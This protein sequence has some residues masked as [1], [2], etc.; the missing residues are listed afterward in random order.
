MSVAQYDASKV[1]KKAIEAYT[2]GLENAQEDRYNEAIQDL[3]EAIQRD[4]KYV[5]AYLSLAGVY[6]Q[7]KNREQSVA[8]YEKAFT[9]DS[10]YTSDFR[11]PYSINLAGMGQFDKALQTIDALLAK[12]NLNPNTR[13]AAEYRRKTYQFALDY[14]K[15][16]PAGNYVFAPQNLGDEINTKES[17][18]FPSIPIESDKLVFTRRLRGMN[19]DFFGSMRQNGKWITA[20]PLPGNINT[21]MNE[22]A[23]NIS[24]DGTMLIFTGCNR[25]GGVGGCD[26]YISYLT[27]N[28]WSEAINLGNKVNSEG[29]DSQP[30]L[31]P[32][33]RDLYFASKRP[34]GLGGSDIYVTHL[35]SNGRWSEPENMGP[36]INTSGDEF[37]PFIHADNQTLYFTSNGLPGYGDEDLFVTR[38]GADGKWGTPQNLGYPINTINEEGTIFVAADSKTAYYSS[39]RSDSRGGL[40]IY[41]F[42]LRDDIRPFK[43]L[44]IKGKVFDKNTNAG[45]P[46]AVELIDLET[47]QTLSKVQTDE[48]GNYLITLPTGKD[49]AFNVNR[50]GYLFYSDNYSLKNKTAD[51]TYE[52]NIP[53]QP[54][55]A[56]AS[57]VLRNIFFDFNKYELKPESQIELDKVVQLLQDNPTVKI[58][59]EGHTD[60]IG[61]AADNLKL[62]ENRA[63]AAIAYISSKGI[64]P[65]R[66]ASKGFGATKPIADNKIEEGR[67]QNRRTELKVVSR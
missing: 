4:P 23:Q 58:Q 57:V 40:D 8:T 50:R 36:G 13:K 24:Q 39:D 66:L 11:L 38:R 63:K 61:N 35:Q 30:S 32:D 12:S 29:W 19:E 18:Y 14:A 45:L 67:A 55:E 16:H 44:W 10:N 47:K 49:Y 62:S 5:E 42:E 60:N 3:Q 54:I 7:M 20:Q 2:R 9:I 64:D 26:I 27:R 37:S 1:N 28:G 21:P 34:G 51:S 56:N 65:K 46:S 52:K 31:S 41:S 6:G 33:K 25:E 22:G 53:L 15:Q 43:T 48:T 17:E 59:I